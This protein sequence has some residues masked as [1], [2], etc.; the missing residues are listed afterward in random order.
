M[1]QLGDGSVDYRTEPTTIDS[2]LSL[3]S[4][5]PVGGL[6]AG[7][8]HACAVDGAHGMWCWGTNDS[9]QLG[10][11]DNDPRPSPDQPADVASACWITTAAGLL[12]TC[13]ISDAACTGATSGELYCWGGDRDEQLGNGTGNTDVLTPGPI[14]GGDTDWTAVYAGGGHTCATKASGL[15][16]W[17]DNQAGEAGVGTDDIAVSMPTKIDDGIWTRVAMSP[18]FPGHT[19]GIRSGVVLCWG[20]NASGEVGVT[21]DP[22]RPGPVDLL[23]GEVQGEV[24]AGDYHSC[25]VDATGALR[26]W[27]AND[28]GQIGDGTTAPAPAPVIVAGTWLRVTC[29]AE[30][31]CA[32]ATDESLWCWG[33]NEEGQ[34]GTGASTPA[35]P[36]AVLTF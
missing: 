27:G 29:G 17:G 11:G 20:E 24:C 18:G 7:G 14:L 23:G 16:C 10:T 15:W 6:V 13:A 12:H 26:C 8:G 32:V 3:W 4:E 5:A 35:S 36:G 31:T 21:A 22:R 2:G 19:C 33:R 25:A 30:H 28:R 34:L 1:S 9:G